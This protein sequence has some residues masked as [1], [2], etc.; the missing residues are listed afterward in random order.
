MYSGDIDEKMA[1]KIQGIIYDVQQNE[2]ALSS[3]VKSWVKIQDGTF[4]VSE[5]CRDLNANEIQEKTLVRVTLHRLC[6]KDVIQKHGDKSGAYR[7]VNNDIQPMNFWDVDETEMN[8][9]YPLY[10]EDLCMTQPGN[11]VI[12]AGAKS[13]G[14]TAF[15]LNFADMNADAWAGNI[16]YWN[17]EMSELELNRRLRKFKRPLD[18]WRT[19]IQFYR[20]HKDFADVIK[21]DAINIIDY[22]TV[23]DDFWTIAGLI[24][25]VGQRLKKGMCLINLQKNKGAEFARGGQST[26]DLSRIYLTL[27][28]ISNQEGNRA[29]IVDAKM[30]KDEE[31]PH[32]R[33]QTCIYSLVKGQHIDFKQGMGAWHHP[34]EEEME[35]EE[36]KKKPPKRQKK[37]PKYGSQFEKE[38]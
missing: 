11:I 4:A 36:E 1:S 19:K 6:K 17:S 28:H 31:T 27:E 22:M 33:G 12:V 35:W 21:P 7:L 15:S 2:T 30:P 38:E 10:I 25:D 32:P 3:Q 13:S 29:I 20:R 5:C 34:T 16:Y 18:D 9:K 14:K 37:P 8:I 26:I 23:Y 24:N